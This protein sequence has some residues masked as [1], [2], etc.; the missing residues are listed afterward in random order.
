[1]ADVVALATVLTALF[2]FLSIAFMLVIQFLTHPKDQYKSN[3]EEIQED[4]WNDACGELGPVVSEV[5]E[6]VADDSNDHDPDELLDGEK[7][8]L[9]LR[10]V[11]DDR[12]DLG[13]LERKLERIDEPKQAYRSCRKNRNDA[14]WWF[15]GSGVGFGISTIVIWFAPE[16]AV[17]TAIEA[18]FITVSLGGVSNG[19][20]VAYRSSNARDELDE[21]VEDEDFM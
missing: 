18:S 21:M 1:M 3:V 6:F 15:L 13:D 16:Q 8:S 20:I 11:L 7:A 14:V 12:E 17:F 5:Y 19:A 9:V 2:S 4:Y 10:R